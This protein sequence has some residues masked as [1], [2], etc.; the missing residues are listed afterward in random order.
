MNAP[1]FLPVMTRKNSIIA[2]T[3]IDR[4]NFKWLSQWRWTL[5]P[6]GYVR[7]IEYR[8]GKQVQV[9]MHHEVMGLKPGGSMRTDHIDRNKLNNRKRNLRVATTAMNSAN[10]VVQKRS[11]SGVKNVYANKY[12]TFDAYI[13]VNRK[14]RH[15]GSFKTIDEAALVA[16]REHEKVYGELGVFA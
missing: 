8:N 9:F 12:G 2:Y 15:L 3:R 11:K 13:T 16:K 1:D 4:T 6:Q 10:T 14:R 7:R 5:N